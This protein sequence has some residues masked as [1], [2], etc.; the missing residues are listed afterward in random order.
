MADEQVRAQEVERSL[1]TVESQ[2][3]DQVSRIQ[4]GTRT[5]LVVGIV[6]WM[7]SKMMFQALMGLLLAIILT[8]NMLGAL[9]IIPS[10]IALIKPRFITRHYGG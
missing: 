10:F 1:A 8:F 3:R 6:F 2:L 7:F 5:T 4:S 9:L